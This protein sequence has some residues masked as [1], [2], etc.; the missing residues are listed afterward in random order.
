LAIGNYQSTS[1]A[2]NS[3]TLLFS[4]RPRNRIVNRRET[5]CPAVRVGELMEGAFAAPMSRDLDARR[6]VSA[7]QQ[8]RQL[9]VV[10]ETWRGRR[11]QARV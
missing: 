1:W 2:A 5:S 4:G 8:L 3:A 6:K 11:I 7:L 10:E 9:C